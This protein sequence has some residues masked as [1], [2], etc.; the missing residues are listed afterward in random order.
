MEEENIEG[1]LLPAKESGGT[2]QE[3]GVLLLLGDGGQVEVFAGG[4]DIVPYV[5]AITIKVL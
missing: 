4:V 1:G 5:C 3:G 2:D